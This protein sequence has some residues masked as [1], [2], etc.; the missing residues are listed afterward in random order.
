VRG[1]SL[2]PQSL[3]PKIVSLSASALAHEQKRY[4]EAGFDEFIAKPFRFERICEC[5]TRLLHAEFE[6][7]APAIPPQTELPVPELLRAQL[8]EAVSSYN[9]T[10]LNELVAALAEV[11]PE[12]RRTADHLRE[13]IRRFDLAQV[14]KAL[15]KTAP[16]A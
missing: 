7:A 11:G 1:S 2:R 5:L 13:L 4:L 10:A 14:R 3:T 9:L 16:R 6:E 12:E 8:L 15:E